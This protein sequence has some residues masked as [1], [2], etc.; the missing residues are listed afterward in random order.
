VAAENIFRLKLQRVLGWITAPI[1]VSL[2]FGAMRFVGRYRIIGGLKQ[3]RAK[4]RELYKKTDGTVLIC[5]NHLTA[6]DSGLLIWCMGSVWTYLTTF[7]MF[8]WNLP[9]RARYEHNWFL[10]GLCYLVS[11]IAM[12]RG[13]DRDQVNRAK[14]QMRY[15]MDHRAA[16]MIF[17]E[18]KRSRNGRVDDKD[19][20][21]GA[22][23]LLQQAEN[24]TVICIYMRGHSQEAFSG[25]PPKG[26]RFHVEMKT[27]KPETSMKGLHEMRELST[28]I[29]RE[30]VNMENDYF[31]ASGQ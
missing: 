10:R 12:D 5:A 21:Y 15:L 28:Q 24:C 13:G 20:S 3:T 8:P 16:I 6:V 14:A 18:G 23:R 31:E 1:I 11:C 22:G 30:L 19:F 17:P 7:R 9:E 2:C 27:I 4:F 29:V 26:A 25:I